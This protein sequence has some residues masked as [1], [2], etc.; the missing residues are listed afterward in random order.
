MGLSIPSRSSMFL[1]YVRPE[2]RLHGF[3]FQSLASVAIDNV[4]PSFLEDIHLYN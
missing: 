1:K 2:E 4:L 3:D